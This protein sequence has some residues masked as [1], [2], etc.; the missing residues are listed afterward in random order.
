M[1]GCDTDTFITRLLRTRFRDG[2]IHSEIKAEDQTKFDQGVT[3]LHFFAS[4]LPQE[5]LQVMLPNDMSTKIRNGWR[6]RIEVLTVEV[7]NRYSSLMHL[8]SSCFSH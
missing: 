7:P 6:L 4:L 1:L 3:A 2:R 5:Y 8:S